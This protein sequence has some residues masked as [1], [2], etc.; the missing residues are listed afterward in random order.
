MHLARFSPVR[1]VHLPRP[2]RPLPGLTERLA[3][4]SGCG[5]TLWIKRDGL[6]GYQ[7][8]CEGRL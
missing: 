7:P 2:F 3:G 6:F 8:E 1:F 4:P 5:P